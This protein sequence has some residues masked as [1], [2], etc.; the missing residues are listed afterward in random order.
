MKAKVASKP[1]RPALFAAAHGSAT[2]G[3]DP[4]VNARGFISHPVSL[5]ESPRGDVWRC[6]R[7]GNIIKMESLNDQA[8]AR[9]ANDENV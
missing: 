2:V 4:C 6:R 5:E 1:N 3:I 9:R 7:C 8:Q